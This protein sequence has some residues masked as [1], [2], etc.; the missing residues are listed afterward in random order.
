MKNKAL[1]YLFIALII[2]GII[3]VTIVASYYGSLLFT[4]E[5]FN[6]GY[7]LPFVGFVALDIVLVGFSFKFMI[8][9]IGGK[10]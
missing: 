7:L 9:I 10:K 3:G 4:S 2:I 8:N 5:T 1:N 6:L